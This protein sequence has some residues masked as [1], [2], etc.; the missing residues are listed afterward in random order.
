MKIHHTTVEQS[1]I[2]SLGRNFT[3]PT[4]IGKSEIISAMKNLEQQLDFL[5][6]SEDHKD[7]IRTILARCLKS[8][9]KNNAHISEQD[10]IFEKI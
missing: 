1:E 3:T 5:D 2:A 10:R 7:G 9:L 6:S 4:Y 8:N